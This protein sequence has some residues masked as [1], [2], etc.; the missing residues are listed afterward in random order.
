MRFLIPVIYNVSD[1]EIRKNLFLLIPVHC[2]ASKQ[3]VLDLYHAYETTWY[4]NPSIYCIILMVSDEGTPSATSWFYFVR[5]M[6]PTNTAN[7]LCQP[8]TICTTNT[9]QERCEMR[10]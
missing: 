6:A 10:R 3:F 8:A 2:Y 5:N 4:R 7:F 9:L 1:H